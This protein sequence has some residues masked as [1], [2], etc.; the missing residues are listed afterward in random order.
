[1]QRRFSRILAVARDRFSTRQWN[2]VLIS[3]VG[4]GILSFRLGADPL[5]TWDEAI[6]ANAARH[7]VKQGYWL[8]PHLYWWPDAL[9]PFLEKP[10]LV[11]WLQALSMSVFGV[12]EFA[13]R[14]PSALA[15]VATAIL[16]YHIGA[17]WYDDRTGITAAFILLVLPPVYLSH[18]SARTG[19]TDMLLV[20]FGSVFVWGVLQARDRPWWFL[21]AGV[22]AG[23]AVLTKGVAAGVFLII[24]LPIVLIDWRE[25]A[26]WGAIKGVA[27]AA[28][29]VLPWIAFIMATHGEEFLYEF[30]YT[31][32]F[33]RAA[34]GFG[35]SSVALFSFMNY[36]Y[37]R[38]VASGEFFASPFKQL[39]VIGIVTIAVGTYQ[40][41]WRQ[42]RSE[43]FLLWWA[44]AVPITFA[45]TGGDHRW[46]LLP[47]VVPATLIAGRVPV[48]AL[49]WVQNRIDDTATY[50]RLLGSYRTYVSVGVVVLLCLAALYPIV[51]PPATD[52]WNADQ[53]ELANAF[54]GSNENETIYVEDSLLGGEYSRFFVFSFYADRP[55]ETASAAELSH[56]DAR[57]AIVPT[58]KLEALE[59]YETLA[60]VERQDIAAVRLTDDQ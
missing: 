6:Y 38:V 46:Y 41:G 60:T 44:A 50:G 16:V 19:D 25:Y 18:H 13:A 14:F 15:G 2:I 17:T 24:L 23:L 35:E 34:G 3:L 12:N 39:I 1:M 49:R 43:L 5:R 53:Q 8:V 30:L 40:K 52:P 11:P 10:P 29:V 59:G 54:N 28:V 36:P 9:V 31:Q 42:S 48:V 26:S 7:M 27:A 57:Y 37:F 51:A 21:P 56:S 32:V 45:L 58:D 20:L 4:L 55:L 22:A 47:M 33:E